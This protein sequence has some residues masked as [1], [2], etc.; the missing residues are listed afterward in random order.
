[1][2]KHNIIFDFG[3]TA[4]IPPLMLWRAEA[5]PPSQAPSKQALGWEY[6]ALFSRIRHHT[7]YRKGRWVRSVRSVR[8]V[9]S[10]PTK[11]YSLG[12]VC[13]CFVVCLPLHLASTHRVV[14]LS[15]PRS[16]FLHFYKKKTHTHIFPLI[17]QQQKYY[18]LSVAD[19]APV[20]VCVCM[21][22]FVPLCFFIT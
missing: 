5:G 1:M 12:K 19:L 2:Q 17:K 6:V 11:S 8:V 9:S 20:C 13:V 7:L 18:S 16:P 3:N 14:V 10:A 22:C 4:R 15:T 21:S